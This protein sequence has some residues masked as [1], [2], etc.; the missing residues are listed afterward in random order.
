MTDIFMLLIEEAPFVAIAIIVVYLAIKLF[1]AAVDWGIS[2]LNDNRKRATAEEETIKAESKEFGV[3]QAE[4]DAYKANHNT[5]VKVYHE[6][7]EKI[8]ELDH[9]ITNLTESIEKS[10]DRFER[11]LTVHESL[12]D[13]YKDMNASLKETV[14]MMSKSLENI[15]KNTNKTNE[16][17]KLVEKEIVLIKENIRRHDDDYTNNPNIQ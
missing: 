3:A 13:D 10:E 15:I 7:Q 16:K 9:Q 12:S 6:Q 11:L 5:L 17:I 4:R 1:R 2:I 14:F 8:N